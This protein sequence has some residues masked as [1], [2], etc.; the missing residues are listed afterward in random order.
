[1]TQRR[2]ASLAISGLVACGGGGGGDDDQPIDAPAIDGLSA[3]CTPRNGTTIVLEPVADGLD[4][5]MLLAAPPHDRR[6][7]VIEQTGAIRLIKDGQLLPTPYMDLGGSGGIVQCCGEQ[8]LL[9]LAF[10]P[11]FRNNGRFYVHHTARDGGDHAFTEYTATSIDADTADPSTARPILRFS[12]PASNHNAGMIEFGNDRM[13]YLAVGDGGGGGDPQDRAQNTSSLFGKLLRIDVDS[14]TGQKPYGI[15]AN[16]PFASSPDGAAD[17][18]PEIWHVGLRNPF[19][20]TF[21]RMTGDIY[22]GDVGQETWEEISAGPNNPGI[23]WG[24][25]DREGMHCFEPS[26]GCATGERIDPV[27][28]F[29]QNDGWASIMGGQVYRGSCFPDLQGTYFYGDHYA[30]QLWAFELSGGAAQ[31]NRQIPGISIGG[32][33]S[34]HEDALGE[35]YVTDIDGRVSRITVQ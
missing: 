33:T 23:N 13:L 16:N 14:R 8:G 19:R 2:M 22:I 26:S 1:M 12:D 31:N 18:R 24:W 9:G 7:F 11:D 28:E 30:G 27:V 6:L 34:I 35:L 32:L 3:T 25:D 20:F 10:H 15:P 17:P 29:N 4:S 5:P 21:D